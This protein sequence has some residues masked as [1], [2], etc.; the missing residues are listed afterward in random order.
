MIALVRLRYGLFQSGRV[1]R[2]SAFINIDKH[3]LGTAIGNRLG[4]GHE[5][6]RNRDHFVS[7]PDPQ[8]EKR[9]PKRLRAAPD[10]DGVGA[11]AV[12]CKV[13]FESLDERPAGE[14]PAVN[15]LLDCGTKFAAKGRVLGIKV[16]K[17]NFHC[18][19]LAKDFKIRAGLP[20]TIVFG[21]TS[22]VTTLPAPT[23]AFSPTVMPPKMWRRN[24]S[25]RHA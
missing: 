6:A 8:C 7:R 11:I 23:M 21:G 20:A 16:K 19:F 22:F 17:R 13:L 5:C 18:I 24:R 1:H 12:R 25:R 4:G 10:A 15:H 14:R 3:R 9:Q 2:V